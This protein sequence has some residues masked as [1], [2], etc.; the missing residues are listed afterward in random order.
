MRMRLEDMINMDGWQGLEYHWA[1]SKWDRARSFSNNFP[2][3]VF[4]SSF[5]KLVTLPIDRQS[6][7]MEIR[8]LSSKWSYNQIFKESTLRKTLH[9]I[10]PFIPFWSLTFP[11]NETARTFMLIG[12]NTGNHPFRTFLC[13]ALA[14][15]PGTALVQP[16]YMACCACSIES[17]RKG[18]NSGMVSNFENRYIQ[19]GYRYLYVGM[20]ASLITNSIFTGLMFTSYETMKKLFPPSSTEQENSFFRRFVFGFSAVFISTI[21][22]LPLEVSKREIIYQSCQ[23]HPD[24]VESFGRIL[25]S[26]TGN[27]VRRSGYLLMQVPAIAI[28]L[29]VFE[30]YKNSNK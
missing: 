16:L 5:A 30:G 20:K 7:T 1:M 13:G 9:P 28:A 19:G 17:V 25:K 21:L 26:C 4:T 11:L 14:S 24:N 6:F 3:A 8:S 15:L 10:G 23:R 18:F 27:V 12:E 22:C 29:I 2:I